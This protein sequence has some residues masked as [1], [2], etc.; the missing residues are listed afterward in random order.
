[1]I[2]SNPAPYPELFPA[3]S[4]SIIRHHQLVLSGSNKNIRH[5]SGIVI[6]LNPA[7]DPELVP[8]SSISIIRQQ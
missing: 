8:A 4:I 7:P 5:N 3:S 6:T 2:S 1:V